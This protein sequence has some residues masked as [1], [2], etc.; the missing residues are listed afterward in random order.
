MTSIS[1][2]TKDPAQAPSRSMG[3]TEAAAALGVTSRTVTRW[4]D[5]G[6]LAHI[7]TLGG[8]SGRGHRRFREADVLALLSAMSGAR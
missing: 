5:A 6:K 2:L 1:D 3:S 4:A 7:R 8:E